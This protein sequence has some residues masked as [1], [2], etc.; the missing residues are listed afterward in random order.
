MWVFSKIGFVSVV[1]HRELKGMLLVRARLREDLE[2]VAA[3]LTE[4]GVTGAECEESPQA[5][6]RFRL[7]CP[8]AA[9]AELLKSLTNEIDYDNFK[10]SVHGNPVRD[11]AYMSCWS[12][13]HAAQVSGK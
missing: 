7:V 10:N 12:A 11:R 3:R 5:D 4:A 13:M 2:H 6:Y 8:R 1:A 9:M